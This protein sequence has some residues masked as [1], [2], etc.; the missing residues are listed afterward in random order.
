MPLAGELDRSTLERAQRGDGRAFA[1]FVRFFAPVVHRVLARL[2]V[3]IDP[4]DLD[5][6]AQVTFLKAHGALPRFEVRSARSLRA[7]VVTIATRVALDALR[8]GRLR[9]VE[10]VDALTP[11]PRPRA[12]ALADARELGAA[13]ATGVARL[14][15]DRRAVFV[16]FEYEGLDYAEIGRTLE[17]EFGTVKSRLSRARADLRRHLLRNGH[18]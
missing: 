10:F 9:E 12:D 16:L 14:S 5:D 2:I 4:I 13:V 8:A 15:A 17:I 3:G 11:S 6:L 18:G 1:R 7:W